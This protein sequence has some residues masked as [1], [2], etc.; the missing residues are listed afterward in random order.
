MDYKIIYIGEFMMMIIKACLINPPITIL[1]HAMY[2]HND[3][4]K[5]QVHR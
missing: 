1:V 3:P 5:K 2:L 4:E